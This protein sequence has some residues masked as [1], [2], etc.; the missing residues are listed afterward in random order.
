MIDEAERAAVVTAADRVSL[1]TEV[2]EGVREFLALEAEWTSLFEASGTQN[3][4]LCWEWV[5]TWVRHF[6]GDRLRTIIVREAD[7]TIAIAPFHL[8]RYLVGP[9]FFASALQLFGPKEV[10]HLFEIREAL[11]L[12]GYERLGAEAI[13]GCALKV[14][15]CDWIE[16]SAQGEGLI[17]WEAALA[18]RS[19]EALS[20]ERE[21][22]I[23]IPLMS[24]EK[25]WEAQ[26]RR[27]KRN[28]KE[29]IRHCYNSLRRDGHGYEYIGDGGL[30]GAKEAANRLIEL[31]RSR[32]HVR[33]RRWHRDHFADDSTRAFEVEA[34]SKM[35][36]AGHVRFSELSIGGEVVAARAFLQSGDALYLHYS[37]FD[38]HWWKYSVMTLVVTEAIQDAIARGLSIVNFSPGVDPSKSRWGVSLVPMRTIAVVR[39]KPLARFRYRLL[40]VRKKIRQPLHRQLDRVLGIFLRQ[41]KPMPTNAMDQRSV[42]T[43]PRP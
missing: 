36:A 43:D 24:L 31:H 22:V 2:L 20:I 38:P 40:R 5:A 21:P 14:P 41:E 30:L 1:T 9:G 6:C 39:S 4:F 13:L 29:S 3:P 27:L 12:P 42:E 33:E 37:G 35:H 26:R 34:L 10:Q 32:S 25:T 11:I 8:N 17:A 7:R 23:Q 19:G 16:I 15:G 18:R 28:I